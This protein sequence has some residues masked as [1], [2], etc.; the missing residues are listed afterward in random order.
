MTSEIWA[1]TLG[2]TQALLQ[3]NLKSSDI[4]AIG[5]TNQ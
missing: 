4:H 2:V 3:A 5:I 1:V